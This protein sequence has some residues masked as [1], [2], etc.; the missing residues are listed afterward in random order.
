MKRTCIFGDVHGMRDLLEELVEKLDLKES[1]TLVSLGDLVDK[2]PDSAGTV[3]YL[4]QLSREA[5]FKTVLLEANHEDRH[6]RYQRN[7]TERPKIARQMAEAAKMLPDLDAALDEEDRAFLKSAHLFLRVPSH[8]VLCLHAGI[9]GNFD[10]FP[11][12]VEEVCALPKKDQQ[13]LRQVLRT[14]YLDAETGR[15]LSLGKEKPGDPFWADIYD[16]RYGHVVFGHQPFF[17][18]PREFPHA[19]GIDTGAVEGGHLT[20]LVLHEGGTR[21]Y[22]SVKAKYVGRATTR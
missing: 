6:I 1:D 20:A 19:T 21:E 3:K 11:E 17:E 7:L 22:V 12:T 9:P 4:G 16:G 13:W 18:G 8:N 5:P 2:G 15:M 10:W 14:R